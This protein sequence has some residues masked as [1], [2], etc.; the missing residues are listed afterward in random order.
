[1]DFDGAYGRFPAQI[2]Y[3]ACNAVDGNIKAL[4]GLPK[5]FSFSPAEIRRFIRATDNA[6]HQII[7]PAVQDIVR[8]LLESNPAL[9]CCRSEE[10]ATA[11]APSAQKDTPE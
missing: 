2:I 6:P 10:T 9:A 11:P 3:G 4:L 1:L 8:E 7:W 5:G